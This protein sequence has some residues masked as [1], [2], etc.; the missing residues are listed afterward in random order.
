[1]SQRPNLLTPTPEERN[2]AGPSDG[3]QLPASFVGKSGRFYVRQSRADGSGYH[4]RLTV[5]PT[6]ED[7]NHRKPVPLTFC[8]AHEALMDFSHALKIYP[9]S[10]TTT[11][12]AYEPDRDE[13][14]LGLT[15]RH[16]WKERFTQTRQR[17]AA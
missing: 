12:P 1:M 14:D 8:D 10:L 16:V 6:V 4:Y 7:Y 2:E 9:E 11:P 13:T 17:H 3:T 5:W 15:P